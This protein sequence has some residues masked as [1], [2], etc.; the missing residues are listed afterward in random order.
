MRSFEA[1]GFTSADPDLIHCTKEGGIAEAARDA[2]M[3]DL[4]VQEADGSSSEEDTDATIETDSADGI[5]V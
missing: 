1:C 5:D 2:I 3:N 4:P